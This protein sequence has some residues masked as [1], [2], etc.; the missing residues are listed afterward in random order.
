MFGNSQQPQDDAKVN[1]Y[2]VSIAGYYGSPV[3]LVCVHSP[4]DD[5]LVIAGEEPLVEQRRPGF[6]MVTNLNLD[7][8]DMRFENEQIRKS[9]HEF[10]RRLGQETLDLDGSLG[11]HSPENAV[12]QDGF[13]ERGPKYRL[14]PEIS[15]GQVA[16]LAACA[17]AAGQ[18]SVERALSLMD[19]ITSLISTDLYSLT[20]I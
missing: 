14:A 20:T 9:I 18:S 2:L 7:A 12:T 8:L 13:D 16:V 10:Q 5:M 3:T 11:R 15:N 19:D 6:G 4:Q 1:M 17:F